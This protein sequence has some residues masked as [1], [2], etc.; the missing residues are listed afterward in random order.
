V[1]AVEKLVQIGGLDEYL[2][3]SD[4]ADFDDPAVEALA[5]E[6]AGASAAE[7]LRNAFELVRDRY[8]HTFQSG[9]E[10]VARSA[11]DVV[12][13]G[14]GLCYAKAFLL[15]ALLRAN[16]IPAGFCYQ[17]FQDEGGFILHGLVA[18]LVEGRW[19]RLDPREEAAFDLGRDMLAFRPDEALGERDYL[20]VFP[21]PDPG[22]SRLLATAKDARELARLLP[23]DLSCPL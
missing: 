16:G 5:R 9:S 7:T 23:Q 20:I 18:A 12:R 13:L 2:R 1:P 22:V 4:S 11:S 3:R 6:V 15:V 17:R 10:G 14:H 8:L 21:K 19:I